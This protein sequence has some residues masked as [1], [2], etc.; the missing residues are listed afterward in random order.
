MTHNIY[1]VIRI[2]RLIEKGNIFREFC[3]SK[4]PVFEPEP[5]LHDIDIIKY[6]PERT[7]KEGERSD[8]D[9]RFVSVCVACGCLRID[10]RHKSGV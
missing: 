8:L 2:D 6:K 5:K 4:H 7:R 9:D 1:L 10:T 3:F